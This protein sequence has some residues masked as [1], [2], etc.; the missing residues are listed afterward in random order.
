MN[1]TI[2]LVNFIIGLTGIF[3]GAA[4]AYWGAMSAI[5]VQLARHEER[6]TVK[7]ESIEK[8]HMRT[9]QRADDAHERLDRLIGRR[10]MSPDSTR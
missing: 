7:L 1:I 2:E 8:M 5:R 3:G 6:T 9:E 4:A 10:N